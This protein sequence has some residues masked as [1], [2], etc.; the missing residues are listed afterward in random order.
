MRV[1]YFDPY[2]PDGYDKALGVRRVDTLREL[3]EQSYVVSLHCPRNAENAYMINE[4]SI[5]WF[6]PGSFLINTAT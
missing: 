4:E 5:G 6:T 2:L 1:S 3:V